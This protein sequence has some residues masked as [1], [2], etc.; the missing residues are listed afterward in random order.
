MLFRFLQCVTVDVAHNTVFTNKPGNSK[1]SS[2]RIGIDDFGELIRSD[3][4][5][6]Q[7]Y[8]YDIVLGTE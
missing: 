1:R 4:G 8:T 3:P 5:Q 6:A 2:S 7:S